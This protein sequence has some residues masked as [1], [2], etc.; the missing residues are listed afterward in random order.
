M[1]LALIELLGSDILGSIEG[2]E[3][4]RLPAA[5][6]IAKLQAWS[7]RY[8]K[9][10]LLDNEGELSAIGREI[11]AWLDESGWASAWALGSGDRALEIRVRGAG[12]VE[13]EAL[14]DAP[15]ELLSRAEGPPLAFDDIQLF[16]VARRIGPKAAPLE[17][18]HG[19]LQLMFMAAAPEGQ[20]ELD[21]EAEETA[22]LEATQ[23]LLLRVVVEETGALE[24]L[25]AR[26]TSDEG[27]FEALHLSCHGD[28]DAKKGPILLLEKAEGGEDRVDA[29]QIVKALGADPPP[30]VVLSA[31]RTAELGGSPGI[32]GFAGRREGVGAAD[33][34]LLDAERARGA[35]PEPAT[36]FVRRLA[37]KIANVLGWDGSVYD[38]D[39]TEFATQFYKELAARS[40]VPRAAAV[41]RQ[42]L[43]GIK[44]TNPDRGRHWHLARV[45][46]G[47]NGGGALC[48]QSKPRRRSAVDG[49]KLFLD[50]TRQRVPVA[51]RAEFVGRRREIQRVLRSF[52]DTQ[53]GMLIHGMGALGKSSLAARVQSRIPHRAVVIFE[54]YDALAIFDEVLQALEPKIQAA[55]KAQWREIVR[56]DPVQLAQA[57]QSWLSDPLDTKP[58]LLII[59][60]LERILETPTQSDA[61]TGVA[62]A[63]RDALAA[64]LLAFDRAPTQS[65][66]LL[67]S[68]YDFRLPDGRGGDL[69]KGLVR[70][71]LKPMA[72]R[73]RNKQWRAAERVA[74]RATAELDAAGKPLLERALDAAAGN[75]GLQAILTKP[76][77]AR[78]FA[79]GAEA[80]RQIDVYR[81][82]GA[83][84]AEIEA[85]IEAGTAKDSENALTAFFARV[86]FRTY[87]DAL[88]P[89]Q[90]RQLGAATLFSPE[91]PIPIPALVAVGA[92][93]GVDAPA[94]AIARLLGLGLLDDWG[95]IGGFPHAAANPLARPLAPKLDEDDRPRLACAA[96]PEL[97]TAWRDAADG[98]PLD[99][100]GLEAAELAIRAGAEP[101]ILEDAALSGAAWL[102]RVRGQTRDARELMATA[103]VAFPAGYAFGPNFLRLGCE[104]A[105]RLGDMKLREALLAAPLR[106]IEPDDAA[107]LTAGAYFNMR[108]AEYKLASGAPRTAEELTRESL[109][110]FSAAFDDRGVA[111]ASGQ[112]AD[113]LQ[114]RGELDLA[115]KIRREDVLPVYERLGHVRSRAVTVGKIADIL[116]AR[117]ELDQALKIRRE[118]QLPVFE[119]LGDVLERARTI[120]KIAD[121]LQ[122]RGELD[123]AL[124]IRREEQLPV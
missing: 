119:R 80:L 42:A 57:L 65:R 108:K 37:A 94:K 84:P 25:G 95:A 69:A 73:E 92:A 48:A 104:C 13:E 61:P 74:G 70:V 33:G 7:K 72:Q 22:I 53:S 26:L 20:N 12:G 46:V 50:K 60:D 62:P 85:L 64:V 117:G 10:S 31:C 75:P 109:H 115:L 17:P 98:F 49:A 15:W 77:L 11:F 111:L 82:T 68:R 106:Q 19:D 78:E 52:R 39:A 123:Q 97:A 113:I 38:V 59:D 76:I 16:V 116:Q 27:P 43:L 88:T 30:L 40:P 32:V 44:A 2:G 124:K 45:Y 5:S 28:I 23:L 34:R 90:R 71:P 118:E 21:F 93:N 83:P 114:M 47:P 8:D 100:R 18:R 55:E 29:G 103:F 14:L 79:A 89:D 87:G 24:F 6:A 54:R 56:A 121:I 41:A 58:I 105:D 102:E 63:H 67:T 107:A 99:H 9:A 81:E 112:I 120:G 1:S 3:E 91:V 4:V 110:V 51:T 101:A 36:P 86:S 96:M 122:A 66:L 35:G